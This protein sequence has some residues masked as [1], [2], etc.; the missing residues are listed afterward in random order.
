[1]ITY[2]APDDPIRKIIKYMTKDKKVA[3]KRKNNLYRSFLVI[4]RN[5]IISSSPK[6]ATNIEG[7]QGYQ[8]STHTKGIIHCSKVDDTCH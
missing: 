8:G 3:S 4:W 1:M 2:K 6:L 7:T 5:Y